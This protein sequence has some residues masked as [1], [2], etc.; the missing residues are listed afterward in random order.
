MMKFSV[1]LLL[2]ISH[3]TVHSVPIRHLVEEQQ[4]VKVTRREANSD[5]ENIDDNFKMSEFASELTNATLPSYLKDLFVNFYFPSE[6]AHTL[7]DQKMT[8]ANTIR[9]FENQA[10][11]TCAVYTEGMHKHLLYN[12]LV[13][14][15]LFGTALILLLLLCRYWLWI[16]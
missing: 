4:P 11:G 14:Y 10:M 5:S 12:I 9:S 13:Y 8:K 2:T 7:K 6:P 1:C 16:L 3:F 15:C